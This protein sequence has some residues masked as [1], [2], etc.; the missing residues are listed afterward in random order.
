[1]QD[2]QIHR[3]GCDMQNVASNIYLFIYLTNII[4]QLHSTQNFVGRNVSLSE[5]RTWQ[6]TFMGIMGG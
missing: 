1:M 5:K 3:L 4:H 2:R 6:I